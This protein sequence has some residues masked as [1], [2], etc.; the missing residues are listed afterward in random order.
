MDVVRPVTR[1][2]PV[3]VMKSGKTEAGAK[4]ASSHTGSIAGSVEAFR[5]AFQQSGVVEA[6]SI[7]DLFD[8]S[9]ILSRI[10]HVKGG[11]SNCYQ[12]WRTWCYGSRCN[13][14]VRA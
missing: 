11:N 2:K 7:N 14:R 10:R 3:V 13:R 1:T 12:F 6:N 9:F 5:A 8:F 4:A